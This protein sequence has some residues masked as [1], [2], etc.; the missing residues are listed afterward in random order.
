MPTRQRDQLPSFVLQEGL[1]QA[2]ANIRDDKPWLETL[3]FVHQGGE[4]FNA[5]E[6]DGRRESLL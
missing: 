3:D 2:L 6:D 4:D 5:V 1:E